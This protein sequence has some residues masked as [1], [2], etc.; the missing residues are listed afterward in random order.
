MKHTFKN[1]RVFLVWSILLV[2]ISVFSQE[3]E[4]SYKNNTYPLY[5]KVLDARPDIPSPYIS[6]KGIEVIV[7]YTQNNK[8]AVIDLSPAKEDQWKVDEIDFPF[9]AKYGLHSESE[10]DQTKTI[11]GRSVSEITDLGR[12]GGLSK[13]GF[14]TTKE[15][16]ISV[17]KGDNIIVKKLGLTH[18]Q[19]AKPLLYILNLMDVE[20]ALNT[21]W[22]NSGQWKN[23]SYFFFNNK[24]ILIKDAI[25]TKGLQ[26]SIF[27]DG[28][29]GYAHIKITRELEKNEKE[30][31]KRKYS[32]L[33]E[34]QMMD[35]T[36][37]I[38]FINSAEMQPYY[39]QWYGFYEGHT[40]WRTD[41]LAIAF[42]FGLKSIEE[43]EEAFP[44]KLYKVLTT[45]HT[46]V[47]Q[48]P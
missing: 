27:E 9:Y 18:P 21:W 33:N 40:F 46:T 6:E 25:L 2:S 38:S 16:I 29:E 45:E 20:M 8:Y 47:Y 11:T 42:I 10:L 5:P 39:I 1:T 44:E 35:M 7:A 31:L 41:P 22:G 14:M 48:H 43:L 17:L 37:R 28:V 23:I 36:N 19:M 30:F 32:F 12:P 13:D 4:I 24:K 26:L 34:E 15:D 3:K